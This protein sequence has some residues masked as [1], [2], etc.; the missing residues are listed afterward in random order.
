[1][2]SVYFSQTNHQVQSLKPFL[3]SSDFK[4][5][6]NFLFLFSESLSTNRDSA[7]KMAET[8]NYATSLT[9][10]IYASPQLSHR[11][12]TIYGS[13]KSTAPTVYGSQSETIYESPQSSPRSTSSGTH[14]TAKLGDSIQVRLSCF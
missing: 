13:T 3:I 7:T 2:V 4:F 10:T 12:A 6:T 9:S 11:S 14:S 8:Q 1:M 5:E